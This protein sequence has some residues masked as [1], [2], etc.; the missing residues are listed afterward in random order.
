M[1]RASRLPGD[2][3]LHSPRFGVPD[4]LNFFGDEL[5]RAAFEQ[6]VQQLRD[7]GGTPVPVDLALA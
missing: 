6:S 3:G 1:R 5:A 7:L 4:A 2:A